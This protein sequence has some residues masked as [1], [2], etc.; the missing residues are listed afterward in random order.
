M[1]EIFFN[2]VATLPVITN[3]SSRTINAEN[4]RGEKGGG[5]KSASC[6]GAGRKGSPCITLKAGETAELAEIEGCGVINHIWITVTDKTSEA[7]RFAA[8]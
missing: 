8:S 1:N 4:P 6:L 3:E 7:N 5:G 2:S